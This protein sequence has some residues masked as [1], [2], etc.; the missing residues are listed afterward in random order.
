[1]L[2]NSL[3]LSFLTQINYLLLNC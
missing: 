2:F 1:M 3:F